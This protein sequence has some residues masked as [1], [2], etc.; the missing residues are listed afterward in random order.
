MNGAPGQETADQLAEFAQPEDGAAGGEAEQPVAGVEDEQG[1]RRQVSG[2]FK[3]EK[4]GNW[5]ALQRQLATGKGAIVASA[6][7]GNWHG[8]GFA[9]AD[10]GECHGQRNVFRRAQVGQQVPR[11]LLPD[12]ADHAATVGQAVGR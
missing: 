11:C 9:M 3:F 5:P 4:S 2:L 7:L 1:G 10:T 6:H 12:E 8:G